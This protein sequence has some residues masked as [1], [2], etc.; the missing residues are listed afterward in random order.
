MNASRTAQPR[1]RPVALRT[2]S[3]R[4]SYAP[5]SAATSAVDIEKSS[6]LTARQNEALDLLLAVEVDDRSQQLPLLVGAPRVDAQRAAQPGRAA[7]LVDVAVQRQRRLQALDRL[8]HRRRARGDRRVP[9]VGQV[10]LRGQ[11][12]RVVQAGAVGRAVQAEDRPLRRGGELLGDPRDALREHRLV[13]L[14]VGIPRRAVR[15]A[16]RRQLEAAVDVDDLALGELHELGL[17]DD[18]VDL[19][20]VVVA[21]ADE[22]GDA[23][24][25]ELLVG[26]AHPALD[27]LE[28][29]LLEERV[30]ARLVLGELADLVGR[31]AERVVAAADYGLLKRLDRLLAL[32]LLAV[33]EQRRVP[34]PAAVVDDRH[35][36]LAGHV[37]AEDHDVGVVVRARVQELAPA[38]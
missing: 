19:E 4:S 8:A 1:T 36:R 25:G 7:R 23:L 27:R 2:K 37:A 9:R 31:G 28:H 22:A 6:S 32:E 29:V 17:A 38:G 35:E 13:L 21:G 18:V 5:A 30:P 26:Q 15:P 24:A 12:R 3:D 33:L 20:L 34:A 16:G 11:L 14:A 10:H